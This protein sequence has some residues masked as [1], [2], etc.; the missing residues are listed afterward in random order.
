M[1][2]GEE[3]QVVMI[4]HRLG[5]AT[6]GLG[7][8]EEWSPIPRDHHQR[9]HD[10]FWKAVAAILPEDDNDE[11][12]WMTEEASAELEVNQPHN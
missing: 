2:S 12:V 10:T 7:P 8:V 1:I 9:R 5:L 11:E 6:E 4:L 3:A